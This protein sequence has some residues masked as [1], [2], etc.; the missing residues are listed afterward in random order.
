MKQTYERM[1]QLINKEDLKFGHLLLWQNGNTTIT[2][3]YHHECILIRDYMEDMYGSSY[4]QE[5]ISYNTMVGTP[6]TEE[7]IEVI[8]KVMVNK[9]K[10]R[11]EKKIESFKKSEFY[12]KLKELEIAK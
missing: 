8:K 5:T 2:D 4:N 3:N 1:E 10:K 12:Q 11:L 9:N 7:V 6:T